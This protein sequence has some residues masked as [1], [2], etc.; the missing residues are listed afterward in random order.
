MI[1]WMAK[2]IGGHAHV[3][4]G[5]P[6]ALHI[7]HYAQGFFHGVQGLV[8]IQCFRIVFANIAQ[9][10]T[11]LCLGLTSRSRVV[12]VHQTFHDGKLSI[13]RRGFERRPFTAIFDAMIRVVDMGQGQG[14]A[15]ARTET[16]SRDRESDTIM[17]ICVRKT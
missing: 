4:A 3:Q 13:G 1:L 15:A 17:S 9:H 10:G 14:E 7:R 16:S 11:G 5:F 8:R 6:R 12:T 2:L